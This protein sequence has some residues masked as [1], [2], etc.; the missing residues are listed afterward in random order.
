M[1]LVQGHLRP[2]GTS[3]TKHAYLNSGVMVHAGGSE[4]QGHFWL[5]NNKLSASLR[6][7][8]ACLKQQP[9]DIK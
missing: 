6:Y 3:I 7:M 9:N 8:K 4:V 5:H 1:L 2:L